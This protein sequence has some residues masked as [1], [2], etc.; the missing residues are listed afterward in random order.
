MKLSLFFFLL[1][2]TLGL[3]SEPLSLGAA[4]PQVKTLD[5]NGKA[6][7]FADFYAKGIT[8]VYFYP[9]AETPGCTAEACSLRDSYATLRDR[10]G[11]AIQILGVSRDKPEAQK[12]FQEKHQL[13]FTLIPDQDGTVAKA[14][15]VT[16]IPVIG[17]TNRQ[18]FLV[19]DGKISW[20]SLKAETS[21][22]AQEVQKA[23]QSLQ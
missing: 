23:L 11:K 13:P 17:L 5:Q 9:K 14:F 1:T 4:A 19:K 2:A 20:S 10:D 8:L 22:A 18:S 15:G 3:S 21:G 6:I 16:L 12:K 7:S